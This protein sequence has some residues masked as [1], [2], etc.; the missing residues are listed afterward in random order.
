MRSISSPF[1]RRAALNGAFQASELRKLLA[2]TRVDNVIDIGANRGQ[3]VLLVADMLPDANI[4]AFE[5]QQRARETLESVADVVPNNVECFPFALG[6][7]EKSTQIFVADEDDSSSLLEPTSRQVALFPGS[8]IVSSE[9]IQVR[10]AETAVP[11]GAFA[12]RTLVKIDVQGMELDVLE[13]FSELQLGCVDQL[14]VELSLEE[15]YSGQPLASDIIS[16]LS[17]RG[18]TLCDVGANSSSGID[19]VQVDAFFIRKDR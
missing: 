15:L 9:E 11:S 1:G 7:E 5:P 19:N 6:A 18:F 10:R 12:E 14:L 17:T 3:F 2:R 8:K 4:F 16:W 13:S